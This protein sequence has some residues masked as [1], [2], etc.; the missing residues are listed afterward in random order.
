MEYLCP[1]VSLG[2][3]RADPAKTEQTRLRTQQGSR[4]MY[5]QLLHQWSAGLLSCGVLL[6]VSGADAGTVELSPVKDNTLI[7]AEPPVVSNGSGDGLYA[8]RVGPPPGDQGRVRGGHG[9]AVAAQCQGPICVGDTFECTIT[10]RT[11]DT[12]GDTVKINACWGLVD[13]GGA[14]IRV[15]ATG[16][17]PG[18][19]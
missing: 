1:A 7:E 15:P 18:R 13:P 6:A 3:G 17:L 4:S 12:F 14:A 9:I 19:T 8:G 10:L 11:E 16:N 5:S 2:G